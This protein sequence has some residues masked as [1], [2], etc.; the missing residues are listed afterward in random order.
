MF[1]MTKLIQTT[2]SSYTTSC[3]SRLP[4]MLVVGALVGTLLLTFA[5][6]TEASRSLTGPVAAPNPSPSPIQLVLDTSGPP[7]DHAAA[8]EGTFGLPDPFVI[9]NITSWVNQ[10]LDRNARINIFV[11]NLELAPGEI[12]HDVTVNL[13]DSHNQNFE[14]AAEVVRLIPGTIFTQV[15]F[16]IPDNIATGKC[17]LTVRWHDQ[18]SN[19]GTVKIRP[20]KPKLDL[21]PLH[22]TIYVPDNC[23]RTFVIKNIG[24]E[25]STLDY[26]VSDPNGSLEV[27]NRIGS[28]PAGNSATI[29]VRVHP[30]LLGNLDLLPVETYVVVETPDASNYI[31][32]PV[33]FSIR[34]VS[35]IGQALLGTWSGT[36]SGVSQGRDFPGVVTPT[37]PV[38][39]TWTL[40]LQTVDRANNTASGT[41]T[42]NGTDAYWTYGASDGT[43][44]PHPFTPNRTFAFSGTSTRLD[45]S[46]F[47]NCNNGHRFHL[48]INGNQIVSD[49]YGPWFSIEMNADSGAAITTGNGFN[50][51]PYNTTN[52]DRAFSHG[53]VTGSKVP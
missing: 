41:L 26:L 51:N 44:S 15:I 21:R 24:P 40:T 4:L 34:N 30:E 37:T 50:A 10:G 14:V 28:L 19:P 8:I 2:R 22:D 16:R 39:G 11:T 31:S 20:P 23:L 35:Q 1:Q 52:G 18:I 12:A 27:Q 33:G 48:T 43:A 5:F 17:T 47:G 6:A 45:D 29:G 13:L 3:R 53:I 49:P 38:S 7:F 9:L 32:I 36:W 25:G 46:G 42:W